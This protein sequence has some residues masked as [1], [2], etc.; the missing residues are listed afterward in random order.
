MAGRPLVDVVRE[1]YRADPAEFVALRDR[2][3]ASAREEGDEDTASVIKKLRRPTLAAWAVNLLR[4]ERGPRVDSLVA[5]GERIRA[6]QRELRGD[7]LR[8]LAIQRSRLL[9]ELTHA[10][11]DLAA[12]S[13]HALGEQARRQEEQTLTAAL[14]DPESARKVCEATLS[15]PLEYSGFGLDELAAMPSE[16]QPPKPKRQRRPAGDEL[17]ERRRKR[18]EEKLA[19]ARRELDRRAAE[20]RSAEE[21]LRGAEQRQRTLQH[22]LEE[23]RDELDQRERELRRE[24]QEGNQARRHL[25]RVQ[26]AHEVARRRVAEL[27]H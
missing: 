8:E 13:G 9:G 15:K 19:E 18:Q 22:R 12:E 10:A 16:P 24:H 21:S 6:A 7:D 23:L 11:M 25:E 17:G 26:R 4:A 20:V 5:L 3:A 14:S 27:D 2:E 1:L